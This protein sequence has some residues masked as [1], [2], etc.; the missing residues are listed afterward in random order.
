MGLSSAHSES[1][2]VV[3]VPQKMAL[4]IQHGDAAPGS[5]DI[6]DAAPIP[7]NELA[8]AACIEGCIPLQL[9]PAEFSLGPTVHSQ[10]SLKLIYGKYIDLAAT[11]LNKF[12]H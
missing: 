9:N 4:V 3:E 8:T 6:M 10:I 7:G 12:K 1:F 5:P 2:S 11:L